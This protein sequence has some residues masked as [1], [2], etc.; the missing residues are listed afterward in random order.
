MGV[1]CYQDAFLSATGVPEWDAILGLVRKA[2]G[3]KG[4]HFCVQNR[5]GRQDCVRV[6]Q[7]RHEQAAKCKGWP[8]TGTAVPFGMG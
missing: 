8:E 7:V 1:S 4:L 3:A 5:T 2:L 6:A